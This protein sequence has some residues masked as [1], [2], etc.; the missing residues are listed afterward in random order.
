M[1]LAFKV[2]ERARQSRFIF[3]RILV[4]PAEPSIYQWLF[5]TFPLHP[6]LEDDLGA[7]LTRLCRLGAIVLL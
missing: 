6:C 2:N 3:D 4:F 1:H 7:S 5:K